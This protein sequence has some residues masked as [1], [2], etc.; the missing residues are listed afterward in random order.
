MDDKKNTWMTALVVMATAM[1]AYFHFSP[2]PVGEKSQMKS[3]PGVSQIGDQNFPARLWEDPVSATEHRAASPI[4][5]C[6][7]RS[8]LSQWDT[9]AEH[10]QVVGIFVEGFAYPED[11]ERRLRL[12]YAAQMAF[13]CLNFRPSDRNNLGSVSLPWPKGNE[14]T[15][16]R[17]DLLEPTVELRYV[18]FGNEQALR[19]K[20]P[21]LYIP[22]E[23]FFLRQE[24]LVKEAV[25]VLWLKEHDF[26]DY[27]LTRLSRLRRA[28]SKNDQPENGNQRT[29][30]SIS[31]LGSFGLSGLPVCEGAYDQNKG[32]EDLEI[33]G[34]CSLDML[35]RLEKDIERVNNPEL[36]VNF[37]KGSADRML[38]A[39]SQVRTFAAG[40]PKGCFF[41][42]YSPAQDNSATNTVTKLLQELKL[43]GVDPKDQNDQPVAIFYEGDTS[44]GCACSGAFC[45]K[46]TAVVTYLRGLDG[47]SARQTEEKPPSKNP[48]S[49]PDG[50]RDEKASSTKGTPLEYAEGNH[51]FDYAKRMAAVLAE[52]Y[53]GKSPEA[54]GIFGSDVGDKLILLR[55]LRNQFPGVT[56]FFTTELDARYLDPGVLPA[57]RNMIIA[58]SYPLH[59]GEALQYLEKPTGELAARISE[60]P[61]FRDSTQ[62]ALFFAC[63][64]A[65][66]SQTKA[67]PP[68][69][70]TVGRRSFIK[71]P[72][73]YASKA[74]NDTKW[75]DWIFIS[76]I[77][78]AGLIW[79]NKLFPISIRGGGT[80]EAREVLETSRNQ[81]VFAS[82][83]LGLIAI[84]VIAC[85]AISNT[86]DESEPFRL[87]DGISIWPTE[88]LRVAALF[89][90]VIFLIFAWYKHRPYRLAL[91]SNYL[92]P[93]NVD[94]VNDAPEL[95]KYLMKIKKDDCDEWNEKK[96]D[97]GTL[98][99]L[100]HFFR[101]RSIQYPTPENPSNEL[102][103]RYLLKFYFRNGFLGYRCWRVAGWSLPSFLLLH[104]LVT[105]PSS[106]ARNS[107]A[108]MF[109]QVILYACGIFFWLL[110]FYV[111]DATRMALFMI[112]K[113]GA[114]RSH[115]PRDYLDK[116]SQERRMGRDNLAGYADVKFVAN[117]TKEASQIVLYPFIV[118]LVMLVARSQFFDRWSWPWSYKIMSV[119]IVMFIAL[120]SFC[121]RSAAR[122]VSNEAVKELNSIKLKGIASG[123]S[124]ANEI[125]QIEQTIG[126]IEA[127]ADGA[128]APWF[129]DRAASAFLIPSAGALIIQLLETLFYT[130]E[131]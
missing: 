90:A 83:I 77:I 72:D 122:K 37:V 131:W 125:A 91:W 81:L 119:L 103:V 42:K 93:D 14:L 31:P 1:F 121:I 128:Y 52:R 39:C 88:L 86:A 56:N 33:V 32:I 84:G 21:V 15:P 96:E 38:D 82:I 5:L 66:G 34:P 25:L 105:M 85:L 10:V 117:Y 49:N 126:E 16:V 73:N 104:W 107:S 61:P 24:K 79:W 3:S 29:R 48:E 65:L 60:V 44:Y 20:T 17:P 26:A 41:P 2:Q 43:R 40:E 92:K 58:S 112:K 120:C 68:D 116:L 71:L 108:R 94:D 62:T 67:P 114:S 109:D 27:P 13:S 89:L 55:A 47:L 4:R 111:L 69:I 9:N 97:I 54:I 113:L 63:L 35:E 45:G 8:Q 106:P 23:W 110:T 80:P 118:L 6:D 76:F 12:R 100:L 123:G 78:F 130:G 129:F 101:I 22:F 59:P 75:W 95:A 7:L 70:Y 18:D 11:R 51:Q 102:S 115:W 74:I 64:N 19:G 50:S 87:L 30:I 28:L 57:T 53:N 46:S 127:E 98:G 124:S 99:R 36:S